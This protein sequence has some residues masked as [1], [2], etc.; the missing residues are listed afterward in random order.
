MRN[1]LIIG[2]VKRIRRKDKGLQWIGLRPRPVDQ[3][4]NVVLVIVHE[5]G[6]I[7]VRMTQRKG[8]GIDFGS[9]DQGDSLEIQ[10]RQDNPIIVGGKQSSPLLVKHCRS[11]K[12]K[13]F[14]G[15]KCVD[16]MVSFQYRIFD[17]Q[18]IRVLLASRKSDQ[19]K[20]Y[21]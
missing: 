7:Y 21:L 17:G 11:G 8:T 13:V 9:A 10:P 5:I 20:L 3:P 18:A 14:S 19:R 16:A 1:P 6:V 2:H 4:D 15:R 12:I